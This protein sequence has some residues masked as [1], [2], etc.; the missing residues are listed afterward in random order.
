MPTPAHAALLFALG[1]LGTPL[2]LTLLTP[3][4]PR[5]RNYAGREISTAA[6]TAFLPIILLAL[7]VGVW[8]VV[9]LRGGDVAFLGYAFVAGVVGLVDDVWGGSG[10]RGFRGHLGALLRGRA[11]TGLLKVVVLGI[12]GIVLAAVVV[13]GVVHVAFAAVVVAGSA[14]LANLFDVRPG[15]AIKFVGVLLLPALAV[16]NSAGAALAA[17]SV[18]GGAVGLFP[19]DVRGRMMLGDA[20]ASVLGAALGYAV[21]A[22]GPG[23]AWWLYLA[24]ILWLTALA[25]VSSI[26]KLIERVGLLRRLDLWGR[27]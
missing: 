8:D 23:F 1:A 2:A 7:V 10:E 26:S 20:G 16:A 9:G 6:G 15:R 27:D 22:G 21:I 11:T 17:W 4:L 14:N 3:L 5:R 24:V 13:D 25:E 12:G 19:S 18:V